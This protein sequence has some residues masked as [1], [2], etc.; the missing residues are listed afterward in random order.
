MSATTH[1]RYAVLAGALFVTALGLSTSANAAL[2][3]SYNGGAVVVTDNGAGDL[4]PNPGAIIS[5]TNLAG[6]GVTIT[7]GTSNSPGTSTAGVIQVSSLNV[8]NLGSGTGTMSVTVSDTGFTNPGGAGTPMV[9]TSSVGGTFTNAA[10]GNTAMFQSFVDPANAQP[11]NA[12]AAPAVNA[13]KLNALAATESFDGNSAIPFIRGAGAYSLSNTINVSLA[14]NG[15]ANISGT[16][17]AGLVPEPV[18]LGALSG[19]A[20]FAARRRR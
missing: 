16:T 14:P 19:V 11:A 13:V 9:L 3:V 7:V 8:H 17:T 4:N 1:P 18:T 20:M 10:V 15:Q 6:F 5:S 2:M 12:I